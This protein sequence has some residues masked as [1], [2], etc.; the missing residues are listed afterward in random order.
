MGGSTEKS[1]S[2]LEYDRKNLT[3][4][5]C[6]KDFNK[7]IFSKLE[8]SGEDKILLYKQGFDRAMVL[9]SGSQ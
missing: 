9:N 1:Y 4:I 5:G 2:C 6:H 8:D 7:F 3:V